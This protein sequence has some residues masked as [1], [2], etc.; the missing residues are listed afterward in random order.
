MSVLIIGSNTYFLRVLCSDCGRKNIWYKDVYGCISILEGAVLTN[1]I[2]HFWK[3]IPQ[4]MLTESS[5]VAGWEVSPHTGVTQL[6]RMENAWKMDLIKIYNRGSF[7]WIFETYD[8]WKEA[9][10]TMH[11]GVSINCVKNKGFKWHEYTDSN[12]R[13][14]TNSVQV[15]RERFLPLLIIQRFWKRIIARW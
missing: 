6:T 14:K 7:P 11:S 1:I 12:R 9:K 3:S 5:A 2:R 13:S 4:R 15:E 10:W 8:T